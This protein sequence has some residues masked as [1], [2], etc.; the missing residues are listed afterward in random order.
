[1]LLGFLLKWRGYRIYYDGSTSSLLAN[2]VHREGERD[3]E[4]EREEKITLSLLCFSVPSLSCASCFSSRASIPVAERF[5]E[6][7]VNLDQYNTGKSTA[8]GHILVLQPLAC[9]MLL[10]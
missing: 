2:N 9:S 6:K 8:Y 1:M 3:R 10:T 7:W 4:R 5:W